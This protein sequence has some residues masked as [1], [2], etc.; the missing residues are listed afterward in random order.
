MPSR[1]VRSFGCAFISRQIGPEGP[2]PLQLRDRPSQRLKAKS[3]KPTPDT[4]LPAIQLF[5][6][7]V[8]RR[9]LEIAAPGP[10]YLVLEHAILRPNDGPMEA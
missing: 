8:L 5:D 10:N 4:R 7:L 2:A 1:E 6:F 9:L 3:Q